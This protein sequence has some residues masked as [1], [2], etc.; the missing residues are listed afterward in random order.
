MRGRGGGAYEI[1]DEEEYLIMVD[2][3]GMEEEEEDIPTA[4]GVQAA[5]HAYCSYLQYW[6]KNS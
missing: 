5:S 6:H 2:R 1:G 4:T 3:N